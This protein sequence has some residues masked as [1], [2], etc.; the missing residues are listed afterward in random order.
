M[1]DGKLRWIEVVAVARQKAK[2]DGAAADAATDPATCDGI[3][4]GQ[5]RSQPL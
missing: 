4:A 1:T 2:F 5:D 3:F